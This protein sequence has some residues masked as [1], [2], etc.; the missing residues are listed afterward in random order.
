MK[1]RTWK[2]PLTLIL[3]M[4]MLASVLIGCNN[5]ETPV[6]TETIDNSKTEKPAETDV[7]TS[8]EE[9]SLVNMDSMMPVTNEPVTLSM[10]VRLTAESS[11]PEDIWFWQYYERKTN[12]KWEFTTVEDTAWNEKKALILAASDYP[13]AIFIRSAYDLSDIQSYG[14]EGTFL[15]LEE[16]IDKYAT[17]LQERFKE[18]PTARASVTCP[19]GH[20]Y[21]MPLISP[22]VLP[23]IGASYNQTWLDAAGLDIPTT[24]DEF[25]TTLQAFSKLGDMNGNGLEDEY[26]WAGSW[27]NNS[28]SV[29]LNAYGLVTNGYKEGIALL[30]GEAVYFPLTEEYKKY[31]TLMNKIYTEGL[32]DPDIFTLTDTEFKAEAME[33]AFG[34]TTISTMRYYVDNSDQSWL[35]YT[36]LIPLVENEGDT[37]VFYKSTETTVGPFILTDNCEYPEVAVRWIDMFY[38]ATNAMYAGYGPSVEDA[39]AMEGWE[40]IIGWEKVEYEATQD[41]IDV[42]GFYGGTI[43][44]KVEKMSFLPFPE[45]GMNSTQWRNKY[46]LPSASAGI[47]MMNSEWF[48]PLAKYNETTPMIYEPNNLEGWWRRQA[49]QNA[50]EYYSE[51][52]PRLYFFNEDDIG[53]IN[54]ILTPMTDYFEQMEARF[55]TGAESLDNYDE[56]INQ[57]KALGATDYQQVLYDYY[58][59]YK[60]NLN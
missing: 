45:E 47:F 2:K 46:V 21:A 4:L 19:D 17:T 1:P 6:T 55:I 59:N 25:Y 60:T 15:A 13:G 40:G 16:Y 42:T 44:E 5:Q 28:R 48:Y 43:P 10:L 18:F 26:P 54:E 22:T 20:I 53:Y 33:E 27:S 37:P 9:V 12:V 49:Y 29:L 8:T 14:K 7:S 23:S 58:E 30:D 38:D 3:V 11:E 51:G 52:F 24:I 35:D 57:L 32:I 41:W 56:F 31:L 36:Y 34:Y 50:Y 39:D